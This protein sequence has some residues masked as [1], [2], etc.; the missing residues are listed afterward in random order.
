MNDFRTPLKR[1]S[2]LGSAQSGTGHFWAQRVTGAANLV[3]LLFVIYS[4]VTL[5][6]EPLSE[7]R[8]YFASPVVAALAVLF[9]LSASYHMRIGMQ[10]IIEDYIH[11][12]ASKVTLLLLNSF[13]A[14]V[15][16]LIST[17][18]I[19]KLSLGA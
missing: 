2:G 19:I 4:G 15:I 11:A 8:D 18:A 5:A 6:G 13:F 14:A 7:V 16:A 1:V 9:A 3:L 10:V 12:P 17:I